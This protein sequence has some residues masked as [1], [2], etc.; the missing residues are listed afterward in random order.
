MAYFIDTHD[1]AKARI[2]PTAAAPS[3][4]AMAMVRDAVNPAP[5]GDGYRFTRLTPKVLM[6]DFRFKKM[7]PRA[8]DRLPELELVT[9]RGETIKT[10]DGETPPWTSLFSSCGGRPRRSPVP[11]W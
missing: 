2:G 1:V 6:S 4:S 11:G 9:T 5:N 7:A 10:T 8:G 3:R